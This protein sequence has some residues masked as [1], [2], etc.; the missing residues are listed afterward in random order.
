MP[1]SATQKCK[2]DKQRM[3]NETED[4]EHFLNLAYGYEIIPPRIYEILT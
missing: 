4:D 1:K 3:Q 2:L